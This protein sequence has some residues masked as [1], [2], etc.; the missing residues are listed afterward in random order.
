KPNPALISSVSEIRGVP[1]GR[2]TLLSIQVSAPEVSFQWQVYKNDEHGFDELE[3][4]SLYLGVKTPELLISKLTP[5]LSGYRYRCMVAGNNVPTSTSLMV[6]LIA[7]EQFSLLQDVSDVTVY[8]G[9]PI[10]FTISAT[11]K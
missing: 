3:N 10:E 1:A 7:E 2:P 6:T 5:D 9:D 4:D 11:G 8:P